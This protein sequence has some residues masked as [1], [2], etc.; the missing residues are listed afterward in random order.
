MEQLF[1]TTV[2][3]LCILAQK[4]LSI[5]NPCKTDD[6]VM[7]AYSEMGIRLQIQLIPH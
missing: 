6:P 1:K 7:D 2:E 5:H 3:A 4:Q